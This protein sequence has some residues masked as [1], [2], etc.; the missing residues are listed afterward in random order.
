LA[1]LPQRDLPR[2]ST[3]PHLWLRPNQPIVCPNLIE[4]YPHK[5]RTNHIA[6]RDEDDAFTC[7]YQR[8]RDSHQCGAV[9]YVLQMPGGERYAYQV[10][11]GELKGLHGKNAWEI[12]EYLSSTNPFVG[13]RR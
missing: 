12:L 6:L 2:F 3:R 5:L 4:G 11:Y 10:Q 9:V 1:Q 13:D 8:A 7:Q